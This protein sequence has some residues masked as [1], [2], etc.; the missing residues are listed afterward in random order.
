[1]LTV[2]L[3]IE[4]IVDVENKLLERREITTIFHKSAGS[5]TRI[6]AAKALAE[7]LSFPVEN[8]KT[9]ALKDSSG[10]METLATFYVYPNPEKSQKYL[11]SYI[12]KRMLS[13]EE[14]QKLLE[15]EKKQSAKKKVES[16]SAAKPVAKK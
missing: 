14:R 4:V 15:A 6:G 11:P 8:V 5:L 10:T 2:E 3:S 7:K 16:K 13:K 9:I 12:F 1:M